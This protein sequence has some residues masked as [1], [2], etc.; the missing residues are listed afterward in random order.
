M[1]HPCSPGTSCRVLSSEACVWKTW[2]TPHTSSSLQRSGSASF[3][4]HADR[5]TMHGHSGRTASSGRSTSEAGAALVKRLPLLRRGQL[6]RGLGG[7]A[8][9]CT[10]GRPLEAGQLGRPHR[11]PCRERGSGLR[12]SAGG[13]RGRR[14]HE[15]ASLAELAARSRRP[16]LI[17]APQRRSQPRSALAQI[18]SS[19]RPL[20]RVPTGPRRPWWCC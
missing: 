18:R 7:T 12:A 20:T 16:A 3:H 15:D 5:R 9:C 13:V 2:T 17:R 11:R 10:R 14:G 1:M 4:L 19:R 8:A 6:R